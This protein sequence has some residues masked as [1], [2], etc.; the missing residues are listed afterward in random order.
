MTR[1]HLEANQLALWLLR[2]FL[3]Q[4]EVFFLAQVIAR[5]WMQLGSAWRVCWI[6]ITQG[7]RITRGGCLKVFRRRFSLAGR[8][9]LRGADVASTSL[10]RRRR[11]RQQQQRHYLFAELINCVFQHQVL[12]D[13]DTRVAK[14]TATR[15]DKHW[16]VVSF[17]S[18]SVAALSFKIFQFADD[19]NSLPPK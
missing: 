17:S 5:L 6:I 9:G 7:V 11:Q 10:R 3:R 13:N 8:G 16:K 12:F 15:Q 18:L 14:T 2:L 1:C 4:P 19:E